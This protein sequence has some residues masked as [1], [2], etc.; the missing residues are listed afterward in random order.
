VIDARRALQLALRLG[1][2]GLFVA[3]GVAKWQDP[4]GFAQE[5]AN[6]QL[7]SAQLAGH[8]ATA[9][10][11]M[12]IVA[13]LALLVG[14]RPWRQAGAGALFVI[15]L[16][17]TFAVTAAAARGLDISCG[18]FGTG[19][20]RVTWLTVVRNLALLAAAAVL[21]RAERSPAASAPAA[22]APQRV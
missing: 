20:G 7:V 9:L 22:P 17:L 4:A 15:L 5:I 1:L 11:A 8:L 21:V 13:G 16:G 12:E 2:G 18:C 19:S 14:P 10:P 3:A 6:Y